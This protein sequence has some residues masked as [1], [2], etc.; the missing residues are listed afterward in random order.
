MLC[1]SSYSSL[2]NT[3][4]GRSDLYFFET[5][6]YIQFLKQINIIYITTN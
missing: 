2:H 6:K 4:V 5:Q 1:T 3:V